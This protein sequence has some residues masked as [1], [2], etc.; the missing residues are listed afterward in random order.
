MTLSYASSIGGSGSI[1]G[2]APN[3]ILKGFYDNNYPDDGL[4]FFTFMV[5]SVPCAILMIVSTWFVLS[6]YWIPKKYIVN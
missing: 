6:L 4:N 3:L 1:V 5:Y 2:T